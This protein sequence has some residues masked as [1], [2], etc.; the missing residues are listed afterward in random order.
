MD[1]I[2]GQIHYCTDGSGEPSFFLIHQTRRSIDDYAEIMPLLARERHVIAMD[3]LGYGD[4]DKP[5]KSYD[6]EDYAKFAITLL[7]E[8][9]VAKAVVVGHHAGTKTAIEMAVAFPD[10]VD[11]LVLLE[12]FFW[13]D[14]AKRSAVS[15]TGRY[16]AEKLKEDGSHL[17]DLWQLDYIR[18]AVDPRI[19]NRMLLDILK[20]GAGIHRVHRASAK[21]PQEE[22]MPLIRCPTLIIWGTR[23]VAW[24]A[25]HN[26]H[27]RG[28]AESI[29]GCQV[30]LVEG[31]TV[32]TPN[33]KP[34]EVARLILEFAFSK[35]EGRS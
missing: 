30:A 35:G 17:L 16:E 26:M 1:T 21:Y 19:K 9:R 14:E 31:G 2:D 13:G 23:D 8:L 11:K 10:R 15:Q 4:S 24:H 7:D 34:A 3:T 20:A 29:P 18:E 33:Q 6:I 12:P 27:T 25:E 5:S 32:A 28:L 22:R